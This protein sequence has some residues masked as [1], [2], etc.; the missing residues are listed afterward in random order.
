MSYSNKI[1]FETLRT[2][3]SST[4]SS[5]STYYTIGTPL[6]FPSYKIKIVNNSNQLITISIDGIN[7]HDVLPATSFTL[8]DETQAQFSSCN[9]PA[10]PAG[11]QVYAK[12]GAAG[13]GLIYVVSQYLIQ[14]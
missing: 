11:T 13:T 2:L 14:G 3:D 12:A 6:K 5:S 4:M 7:D 10:L 8:Y 1:A 9:C